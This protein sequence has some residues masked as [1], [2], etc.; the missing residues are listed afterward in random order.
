[1]MKRSWAAA[2]YAHSLA[3]RRMVAQRAQLAGALQAL[4][5]SV[6]G[7][8][9]IGLAGDNIAFLVKVSELATSAFIPFIIAGDWNIDATALR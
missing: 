5:I 4:L 3:N 8:A 1:M 9:N 2:D 7:R 6:Y